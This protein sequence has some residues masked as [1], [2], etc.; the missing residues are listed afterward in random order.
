MSIRK[1]MKS[2]DAD[3]DKTD[4]FNKYLVGSMGN[5]LTPA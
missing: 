4:I 1:Y 5:Y 3:F 2:A